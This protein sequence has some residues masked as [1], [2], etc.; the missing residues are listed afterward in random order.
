MGLDALELILAWEEAFGIELDDDEATNIQTPQN[1]IDLIA[2]K[3]GATDGYPGI[4]PVVRTFHR[5][6]QAFQKVVGLQRRQI[7]LNSDLRDLLPRTNRQ[8]ILK[9]IFAELGMANP[10]S[11]NLGS[12]IMLGPVPLQNLIDWALASYPDH[13]IRSDE[14]WTKSQVRSVVR[15]II[16]DVV[17]VSDFKDSHDFVREIIAWR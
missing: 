8:G 7:R 3:V 6:R 14:R 17:G 16:R 11:F 12:G 2:A 10:A 1:A 13:F 9:A 4:C 15:A 5:V